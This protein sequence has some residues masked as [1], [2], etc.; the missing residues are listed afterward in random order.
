MR[1]LRSSV[2]AMGPASWRRGL[3][4]RGALRLYTDQGLWAAVGLGLMNVPQSTLCLRPR[5]LRAELES[6]HDIMHI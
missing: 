5:E 3:D 4:P 1:L 2:L 6:D